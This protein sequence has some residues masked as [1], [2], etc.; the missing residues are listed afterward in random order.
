MYR[1]A[2]CGA[3]VYF[4]RS[5][6]GWVLVDAAWAWGGCACSIRRAAE[7]L[8]GTDAR[9]TAI[10]LTHLHPD[11]DGAALELAQTWSC[12]VYLHPDELPLARAV[13]GGDLAGIERY[14]NWLDR[15]AIVPL[16]RALRRRPDV[17]PARAESL[18]H[19]AQALDPAATLPDLPDWTC[20]PTP[21]HTPGHVAFF[22]ARDRA[23][24]T[25]D[26]VLTVDASSLGGYLAW[27]LGTRPPHACK[28]P[29]YTNW[30]QDATDASLAVLAS[31]E[32]RVLATGHGA[33]LVG[34][35]AAREL[36][37][38]ADRAAA[39]RA[40]AAGGSAAHA[41]FG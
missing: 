4:V 39:R 36:R 13:A 32:P 14:G 3:N 12:P 31:L 22:R 35:T 10:L 20:V 19:V 25:G 8:F 1:L 7:A 27:V 18:V 9:P 33:P 2:V 17:T 41:V 26:A 24:L 40:G 28:P 21:G 16:L 29:W 34:E 11:H 5:Q 37:A 30:R 23:L 6:T 15:A 38:L